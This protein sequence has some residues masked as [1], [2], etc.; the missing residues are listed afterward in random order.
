[1][2][3]AARLA[4]ALRARPRDLVVRA[5]HR[6][7]AALTPAHRTNASGNNQSQR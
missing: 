5:L 4:A 1:M 2:S 3:V 7:A 6:L